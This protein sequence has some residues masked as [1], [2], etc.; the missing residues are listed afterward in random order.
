MRFDDFAVAMTAVFPSDLDRVASE[1]LHELIDHPN[2]YYHLLSVANVYWRERDWSKVIEYAV[3]A[4]RICP[5]SFLVT[6]ML[7]SA[8]GETDQYEECFRYARHLTMLELP[9]WRTARVIGRVLRLLAIFPR[10]RQVHRRW[11][12]LWRNEEASDRAMLQFSTRFI[13]QNGITS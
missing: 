10:G 1:H 5:D 13:G 4:S 8:Y 12:N 6:K 3:P 2:S 7:A 9:S 11:T